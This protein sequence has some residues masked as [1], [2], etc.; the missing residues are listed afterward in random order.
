[1]SHH[2][3]RFTG[4]AVSHLMAVLH[5][6]SAKATPINISVAEEVPISFHFNGFSH[7]V[8]M[9]TPDDLIDFTY[10]F[11]LTEGIIDRAGA[12]RDISINERDD[13]L[14]IDVVLDPESLR[15]YLRARRI[16][17]A[18]GNTSCGLCGVEDLKDLR[19]PA[20]KVR[21]GGTLDAAAIQ[22]AVGAL[23]QAQPLSRSTRA[24]HASA[25]IGSD[26]SIQVVR[27]DI[28]RHNSLDKL[29]GAGL[30]GAFPPAQGFCLITSRCS[31][32]M[33]Q[34]AIAADFATLVSVSAPTAFA[35][36]TAE[37]AG[38]TLY[39]L[40]RDEGQFLYTAPTMSGELS[41]GIEA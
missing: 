18:S 4:A 11:S 6:G 10:G 40:S 29:I 41:H 32:E 2:P 15:G 35:I 5:C 28:G 7:A 17:Q 23:R 14:V 27:E 3:A 25:W 13:G 30:R 16:R 36:R 39:S 9:A 20:R 34:K 12:I 24:A 19:R 21:L 1:M 26:G 37:A 38:L 8:M 31:Y 33:A 22:A